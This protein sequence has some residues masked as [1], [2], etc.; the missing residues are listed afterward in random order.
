M[1]DIMRMSGLASGMNIEEMVSEMVKARR[2]PINRME[3]DKQELEWKQ[4]DYR[5]INGEL[6]KLRESVSDLRFERT[7]N[8]NSVT[9]SNTSAVEV[10]ANND[11][12]EGVYD[13][14]VEQLAKNASL[15]SSD[16]IGISDETN[17]LSSELNVSG[18]KEFR[19]STGS[20]SHDFTLDTDSESMNDLVQKIN[21]ADLGIDASY[22]SDTDRLFL[23]NDSTGA[24]AKIDIDDINGSTGATDLFEE[25]LNININDDGS[26]EATG[27]D[28]VFALN[29]TEL[30]KSTNQFT[31]N[32]VNYN[33]KGE[34]ASTVRVQSDEEQIFETI[35]GFVE[36]YNETLT[37]MN[38]KLTEPYYR[39]YPPLTDE[40]RSELDDDQIEKWTEKAQSGLLKNDPL[41]SRLTSNMRADMAGMVEDVEGGFNTLSEIGITTDSY[42]ERGILH[43]DENKLKEAIST[44]LEGVKELFR[45]TGSDGNEA[46][47]GI[48][49]RLYDNTVNGI[50]QLTRKAGVE[51][52]FNLYDDS[53]I[54]N[55][56]RE[57]DDRIERHEERIQRVEDRYWDQ[58][59]RMEEAINEMNSQ[60]SWLAQQFG[61]GGGGQMMG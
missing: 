51:S 4:E 45:A 35:K 13:I 23:S 39:D 47:K 10:S 15:T 28:A 50:S 1:S 31:L 37:K 33:L 53:N 43:I 30:T 20:S 32:D 17:A 38:G 36:T 34:G 46:S 25:N 22:D 60:S 41:L 5:D 27:L 49:Q 19:I 58:F 54:G 52:D 42:K 57:I 3:Q 18:V 9:S 8:V 14:D 61:G 7:F 6:S 44:D 29:G 21:D 11:A 56:I 26:A 16:S 55:R 48:A 40:T 59:T 24:D 2:E 12:S